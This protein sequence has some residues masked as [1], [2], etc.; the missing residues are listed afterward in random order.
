MQ[1]DDDV[2]AGWDDGISGTLVHDDSVVHVEHVWSTVITIRIAATRGRESRAL[3]AVRSCT[4]FFAH[5]DDVFSAF[6]PLSE[7]SLHRMGIDRSGEH[8]VEFNEVLASC[9]T[10]RVLTGGAFDPWAVPGGYDPSGYVKGW[11]AGRAS[12]LLR[13]AGF[14][15]NVV[16]AGGD[17]CAAGDEIPG[18]GSGWPIGIINPHSTSEVIKVVALRDQ[19]MAT[20]G[21]YER[22]AHVI[23]PATGRAAMSVDSATVVGPDAGIADAAASAALV[24]GVESMKWFDAFGSGW[25]L[26][27][28][29]GAAA[30][31]YGPAFEGE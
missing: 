13:A 8:S 14:D 7:V 1:S 3:E 23:D 30:H 5:V 11:A 9:R 22:G 10:V 27:L 16:N 20:S 17:I 24:D 29:I 31:T 2:T 28:V 4:A 26:H 19:A 6:R 21:R 12:S 18:S 25:S 15:S